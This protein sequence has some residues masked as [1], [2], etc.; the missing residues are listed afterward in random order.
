M[1]Q[2][3]PRGRRVPARLLFAALLLAALAASVWPA[4]SS[5]QQQEAR[6]RRV[7][8]Q[9][10]TRGGV[11][12]PTP[13]TPT[14]TSARPQATPDTAAQQQQPRQQATPQPSPTASPAGQQ[15]GEEVDPD[16][17]LKVDTSLVNL[18][19]RVVDRGNRPVGDVRQEEFRVFENGV[20]QKIEF[21]SKEEVP[22]HYGLVVDNSQSMRLLLDKVIE[23]SKTIINH[24]RPGD[25]TFL[26][27]FVDN[28]NIEI[29]QD[30]TS[31]QEDL[32]EK[33]EDLYTEGGQTAVLDAVML[34]AEHAAKYKK[35]NPLTDRRRRALILIT[36]GEDRSSYY[37]QNEIFDALRE[38]DVQI[39][40]IGFVGELEADNG[41]FIKKSTKE[42]AV[43]L[44]NRLA[45]ESGGRAFFP[46]SL[47]EL[48]AI[49]N[50]ITK[51][52]RTQYV[53]SYYPTNKARDGSFRSVRVTVADNTKREKRIAITRPG[54]TAPRESGAASAT[55]AP[56]RLNAERKP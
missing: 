43:N 18:H 20:P 7:Q 48:P 34:S 2:F 17:V 32:F 8:G 25:E 38:S 40:V 55:P 41:G 11:P 33:L 12:Q 22:I 54:Y 52:L 28:E 56:G 44:I 1:A 35:G 15:E 26:V 4:L 47:A 23:A 42:K 49:A 31:K 30:F 46:N 21:I 24:N 19:V 16:E 37:K 6:P 39:Y 53:I 36:D 27:R 14:A 5:A 10:P 51:D 13:R 3:P 45:S 9:P 29:K 50:E